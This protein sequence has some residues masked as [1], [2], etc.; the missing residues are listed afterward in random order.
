[1]R[2]DYVE[3]EDIETIYLGGGTPSQLTKEELEEI[4]TTLYNI[5]RRSRTSYI[6]LFLLALYQ[7]HCVS[8]YNNFLVGR[9]DPNFDATVVG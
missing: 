7:S 1:M 8:G 2:K 3:G 6:R 4:F 5:Y 9:N